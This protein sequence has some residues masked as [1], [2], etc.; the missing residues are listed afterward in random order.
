MVLCKICFSVQS[1]L[2]MSLLLLLLLLAASIILFQLFNDCSGSIHYEH[3]TLA[4]L[5]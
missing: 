4:P 5:C 2:L 3:C 1:S